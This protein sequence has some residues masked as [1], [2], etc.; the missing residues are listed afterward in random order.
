M[1]YTIAVINGIHTGFQMSL[2]KFGQEYAIFISQYDT[3]DESKLL[4]RTMM[5]HNIQSI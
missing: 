2:D 1:S 5:T 3:E 4:N